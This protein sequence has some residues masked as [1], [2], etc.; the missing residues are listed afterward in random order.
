MA[1]IL[2]SPGM[3]IKGICLSARPAPYLPLMASSRPSAPPPHYVNRIRNIMDDLRIDATSEEASRANLARVAGIAS[4]VQRRED[5]ETTFLGA[6]AERRGKL[7]NM[8]TG[9]PGYEV[10]QH[11]QSLVLIECNKWLIDAPDAYVAIYL[12]AQRSRNLRVFHIGYNSCYLDWELLPRRMQALLMRLMR[13]VKTVILEGIKNLP[14]ALF[15]SL[16]NVQCLD[17]A[18]VK[19]APM[20]P[21]YAIPPDSTPRPAPRSLTVHTR[22]AKEWTDDECDSTLDT[23]RHLKG[24]PAI[25]FNELRTL[26]LDFLGCSGCAKMWKEVVALCR[27][28]LVSLKVN[29]NHEGN[30]E[31]H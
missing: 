11:I 18:M 22:M 13:Q 23:I 19:L 8:L 30:G 28:T 9:P 25:R 12:V 16:G 27:N 15:Y 10:G 24:Y 3:I 21:R 31:L 17:L 4:G 7:I 2:F 20:C 5:V 14:L 1:D 26:Y 6:D 29:Y